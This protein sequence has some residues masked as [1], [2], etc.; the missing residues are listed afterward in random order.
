MHPQKKDVW[1]WSIPFANGTCSLGVVAEPHVI[2]S[3]TGNSQQKLF[4]LIKQT[5]SLA[6][7]LEQA[8]VIT[9]V[10][11]ITGYSANVKS[12]YGDGYALL[13]NAGEFLDPVFFHRE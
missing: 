1:F 6:T 4:E 12:L 9:P 3:L 13:G 10:Q 11:E 7:L 2:D 5:P 8:K